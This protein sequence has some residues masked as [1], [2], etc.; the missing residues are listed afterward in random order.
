VLNDADLQDLLAYLQSL[1]APS[2]AREKG[3]S[4]ANQ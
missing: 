2:P 4:D 1:R 3:T